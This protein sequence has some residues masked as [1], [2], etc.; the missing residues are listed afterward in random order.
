M[1]A[2]N[3]VE[4]SHLIIHRGGEEKDPIVLTYNQTTIGK[5]LKAKIL[6]KVNTKDGRPMELAKGEQF[7]ARGKTYKVVDI[8]IDGV[9]I[10]DSLNQEFK[11]VPPKT[12][13]EGEG[14]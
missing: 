13:D 4:I 10:S 6:N 12:G 3:R 2:S 8:K 1:N 5:Q 14:K 7:E 11:I 9:L